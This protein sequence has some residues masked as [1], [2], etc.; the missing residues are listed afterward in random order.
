MKTKNQWIIAMMCFF[1]VLLGMST[2]LSAVQGGNKIKVL[3]PQNNENYNSGSTMK[4]QWSYPMGVGELRKGVNNPS[5]SIFLVGENQ[6]I[7][8]IAENIPLGNQSFDWKV[9]EFRKMKRYSPTLEFFQIMLVLNPANEE[10]L[11]AGT[12]KWTLIGPGG[13]QIN[14]I[15][16]LFDDCQMYIYLKGNGF[17]AITRTLGVKMVSPTQTYTPQIAKWT[18]TQI[19][20]LL[21]G[22]YELG[23]IYDFFIFNTI[24]QQV[25]SNKKQYRLMT[26][27]SIPAKSYKANE[28]AMVSGHLLGA[29]QG[30]SQLMVGG[31]A[32]KVTGWYCEDIMFIIPDLA[33]G[34]YDIF[35]QEGNILQSNKLKIQIVK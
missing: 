4:I 28:K 14:K 30:A 21:K 10:Y 1:M 26:K 6:R 25:Q 31:T 20:L 17:G 29:S 7:G 12:F 23:R 16:V 13:M 9:G 27:L 3:S 11:S 15:D 35:L 5:I 2:D 18:P 24:S 32:A 8:I 34:Y 22:N 33:P 19:D